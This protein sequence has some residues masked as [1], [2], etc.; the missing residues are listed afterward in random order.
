MKISELL[1][2]SNKNEKLDEVLP[3]LGALGGLALRAA[4]LLA[5]GGAAALR[6]VGNAVSGAAS[7]AGRAVQGAQQGARLAKAA[8]SLTPQDQQQQQAQDN[9]LKSTLS[10][11]QGAFGAAG[12]PPLDVNKAA[13]AI[14]TPPGST[15]RASDSKNLQP[16]L[17]ALAQALKHSGSAEQIAQ[18]IKT[19]VQTDI[20]Q[21]TQAQQTQAQQALK[22]IKV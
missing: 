11:L 3:V 1:S 16:I 19:G 21:Q 12:G 22:S 9:K 4:P 5:R 13:Q 17:P 15:P 6:G 8:N 14:N 20:K 7:T 18:A 10:K 2:P